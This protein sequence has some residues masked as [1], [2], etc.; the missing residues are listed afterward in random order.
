MNQVQKNGGSRPL[1]LIANAT[2]VDDAVSV[3]DMLIRAGAHTD[4]LDFDGF[5]PEQRAKSNTI[6][7]LL[8]SRR[9]RSLKCR[10][11]QLI[12]SSKL[13]YK[14]HLSPTLHS[15]IHMHQGS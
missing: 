12:I 14:S 10:C 1:H 7:S 2:N 8:H 6:K 11:V 5:L 13:P 3:I 9:T 4:C 15:F